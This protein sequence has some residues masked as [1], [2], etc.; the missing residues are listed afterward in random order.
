MAS[1]PSGKLGWPALVTIVALTL[2]TVTGTT[3]A[4]PRVVLRFTALNNEVQTA[5]ARI[6]IP[7]FEARNPDIRVEFQPNPGGTAYYQYLTARI[8]G[9][10]APDVFVAWGEDAIGYAESGALL[11]LTRWIDRDREELA[12]RDFLPSIWEFALLRTGPRAGIRFG[13]PAKANFLVQYYHADWIHEAGLVPPDQLPRGQWN[14]AR[15]LE[16]AR[17]LTRVEGDRVTRYGY[18]TMATGGGYW[19]PW[20]WSGGGDVFDPRD[21]TRF[22]MDSPLATR[23]LQFVQDLRWV[24]RVAPNQEHSSY[25]LPRLNV[26]IED[27]VVGPIKTFYEANIRDSFAWDIAPLPVG[28]DGHHGDYAATDVFVISAT[29]RYPEEAWRFVKFISSYEAMTA[30]LLNAGI[31]P[32]RISAIQR[33]AASLVP[34]GKNHAVLAELVPRAREVPQPVRARR[35]V[36][37]LLGQAIQRSVVRNEVAV[38]VA[39]AEVAGQI[40]SLLQGGDGSVRV[41]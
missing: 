23:G 22:V 12:I 20:V 29:T 40:R 14:W 3:A 9:G 7:L 1:A 10:E 28:P 6:L 17:K 34:R 30:S 33:N 2:L 27:W 39:V 26:A 15:V 25:R 24:H 32:A 35:E 36:N 38:A 21:P 31:I 37:G 5:W 16:Y 13:L 18:N 19:H 4:Q 11:D 41:P 8:A